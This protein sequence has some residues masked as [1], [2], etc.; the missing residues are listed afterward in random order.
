MMVTSKEESTRQPE[1]VKS[2]PQLHFKQT[3]FDARQNKGS[4]FSLF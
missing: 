3:L 4:L 1:M 2:S